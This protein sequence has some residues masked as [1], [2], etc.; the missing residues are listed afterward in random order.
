MILR[1][2]GAPSTP[3]RC[4]AHFSLIHAARIVYAGGTSVRTCAQVRISVQ[5]KW[6]KRRVL[7]QVAAR[8]GCLEDLTD[9]VKKKLSWLEDV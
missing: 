1:D 7:A 2:F 8:V 6:M 3:F 4:P 5:G 9:L